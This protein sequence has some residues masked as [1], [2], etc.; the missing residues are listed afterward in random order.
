MRTDSLAKARASF[1]QQRNAALLSLDREQIEA[2][3]ARYGIVL[4]ERDLA[5][6]G[7]VHKARLDI[8]TMPEEAKETSRRW[9]AEHGLLAPASCP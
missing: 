4:P 7:S 1:L 6:W 9:L 8:P 5:W 3:C 2:Y